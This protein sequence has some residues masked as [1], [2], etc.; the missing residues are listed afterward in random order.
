MIPI[1]RKTSEKQ[2]LPPRYVL[3]LVTAVCVFLLTITY[4]FPVLSGPFEAIADVLFV[5]FQN[6]VTYAGSWI[7]DKTAEIVNIR[8]LEEENRILKQQI[9]DL[10]EQNADLQEDRYEL[11][12]L[13]ELYEL[14]TLYSEYEKTAARIISKDSGSWYH[15]FIINKG[16]SNG[17][18][19]DMNVIAG[20]GLVG[21][22][23]AV[24]PHWARVITIIDDKSNVSAQVLATSDSLIVSGDLESYE[25]GLI[26]F[27]KLRDPENAVNP[28]DKIV[29]SN[30]SDKYLPGI[31][32]GYI[33]TINDDPNHLTKSGTLLPAVDFGKLDIVLVIKEVKEHENPAEE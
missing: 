10:S 28:G 20:G 22:V 24:G 5:P 26:T 17:I 1:S 19:T 15:S 13:R 3:L 32:I 23:T 33:S 2:Q 30:I 12:R 4:N 31:L 8:R 7:G 6:G 29:T 9:A 14:D 27:S 11:V 21:R 25:Q 16:S 18:L